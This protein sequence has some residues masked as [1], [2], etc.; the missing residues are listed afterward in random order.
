MSP[1]WLAPR[2]CA[3]W[4]WNWNWNI[5]I[6]ITF[7]H[8]TQENQFTSFPRQ[9]GKKNPR[10][11]SRAG[12]GMLRNAWFYKGFLTKWPE[13]SEL[14][15][16]FL[17]AQK[18]TFSGMYGTAPPAVVLESCVQWR[19]P[20]FCESC[21]HQGPWYLKLILCVRLFQPSRVLGCDMPTVMLCC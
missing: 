19:S 10:R 5:N 14:K 16:F 18:K 13:I 4:N 9:R 7:I 11:A 21:L 3:G 1:S 8:C 6:N 20:A 12:S 17:G 15:N 2:V